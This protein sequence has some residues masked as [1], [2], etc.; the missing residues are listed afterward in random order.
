MPM[1]YRRENPK[2]RLVLTIEGTATVA[3]WAAAVARQL[4]EEIWHYAVL[5]DATGQ[6]ARLPSPSEVAEITR[7]ALSLHSEIGRRGP[8]AFATGASDIY[9]DIRAW[10]DT[11]G[12]RLPYPT[13]VFRTVDD[14]VRWLD[15]RTGNL[16]EPRASRA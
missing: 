16:G 7:C 11:V 15:A 14:A 5:Y 13:E 6:H 1:H 4:E 2:E 12:A 8:I 10:C 3:D 9:G